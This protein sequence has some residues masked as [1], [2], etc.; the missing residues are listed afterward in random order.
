MSS[1]QRRCL[2]LRGDRAFH[3]SHINL[4]LYLVSTDTG[5]RLKNLPQQKLTLYFRFQNPPLDLCLS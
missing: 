1:H 2:S 5:D 4:Q 3:S